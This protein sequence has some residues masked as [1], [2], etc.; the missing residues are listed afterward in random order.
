VLPSTDVVLQFDTCLE[1]I[2]KKATSALD[3]ITKESYD[4]SQYPLLNTLSQHLTHGRP[5]HWPEVNTT[6][7]TAHMTSTWSLPQVKDTTGQSRSS[8]SLCTDQK[9][10]DSST[11]K[12]SPHQKLKSSW[13]NF[14]SKLTETLGR[15]TSGTRVHPAEHTKSETVFR[16]TT[17]VNITPQY[18]S[19]SWDPVRQRF[20]ATHHTVEDAWGTDASCTG[21]SSRISSVSRES[22]T[23]SVTQPTTTS[24]SMSIKTSLQSLT[25]NDVLSW[26]SQIK[27]L[28]AIPLIRALWSSTSL[29]QAAHY[30]FRLLELWNC[31]WNFGLE[32]LKHVATLIADALRRFFRVCSDF[33][34]FVVEQFTDGKTPAFVKTTDERTMRYSDL[35]AQDRDDEMHFQ[36]I[37]DMFK[38]ISSGELD[39]NE[40]ATAVLAMAAPVVMLMTG[41]KITSGESVAKTIVNL[42]NLCR[43][44]KGIGDSFDGL[45]GLVRST[46][47]S[48]LGLEDRSPRGQ[49]VKKLEALRVRLENKRTRL[50]NDPTIVAS[51]TEFI[52]DLN[53]DLVEVNQMH[54]TIAQSTEN[55]A[56][57]HQMLMI[58]KTLYTELNAKYD[59]IMRTIVGKQVPVVIYLY[60]ESGCGKSEMIKAIVKELSAYHG[61]TLLTYTRAKND[62]YWSKYAGQKIVVYDD[63]NSTVECVDHAEMNEIYSG[64]SYLLP[65]AAVE[66]K[67]TRF[68]S[69]YVLIASNHS[70]VA[71]SKVLTNPR[72]LDRR[73]D[74][75]VRV[76]DPVPIRGNQNSH[77]RDHYQPDFSHVELMRMAHFP[78]GEQLP[79]IE[80]VS[81]LQIVNE[82]FTLHQERTAAYDQEVT[83][84][85]A[86]LVQRPPLPQPVPRAPP[87]P[88]QLGQPV[89][90]NPA[91]RGMQNHRGGNR[92]RG[93]N[94]GQRDPMMFVPHWQ[95]DQ[96]PPQGGRFQMDE[97]VWMRDDD[98]HAQGAQTTGTT[99]PVY[100]LFGPPGCGK[101]EVL[102]GMAGRAECY[103]EFCDS[104]ERFSFVLDLVWR[105]YNGELKK[106]L[107]LA[108]NES[109]FR[110][111]TKEWKTEDHDRFFRRLT[112]FYYSFTRVGG[113]LSR[114]AKPSD[115]DNAEWTPQ[116]RTDAYMKYVKVY[117][118][119]GLASRV[120]TSCVTVLQQLQ[121]VKPVVHV[122]ED[123]Q[124]FTMHD[125]VGKADH[126]Y[127]M[128]A[129]TTDK[130]PHSVL[131]L[132]GIVHTSVGELDV[133]KVVMTHMLQW[134]LAYSNHFFD[135]WAS[136]FAGFGCIR[137]PYTGP[138]ME[139]QFEDGISY[140]CWSENGVLL[141]DQIR[142]RTPMPEDL[143]CVAESHSFKLMEYT[144][145]LP[146]LDVVGFLIKIAVGVGL[147]FFVDHKKVE[148]FDAE[149]WG[150]E[151]DERTLQAYG[152]VEEE[153]RA[154]LAAFQQ[155]RSRASRENTRKVGSDPSGSGVFRWRGSEDIVNE[156]VK[157]RTL[158][159]YSE[160][161]R[162]VVPDQLNVEGRTSADQSEQGLIRKLTKPKIVIFEDKPG[163]VVEQ[164][165]AEASVD[166]GARTV[167]VT[168]VRN[169]VQLLDADQK[170]LC[171]GVGLKDR[172][173]MSVLHIKPFVSFVKKADVVYQVEK[174]VAEMENRDVW[175]FTLEKTAPMFPDITQHLMKKQST[176]ASF[177]GS[178][179]FFVQK[180]STEIMCRV[181]SL[182]EIT[183]KTVDGHKVHGL[184]Y[185]GHSDGFSI[186]PIETKNGDC[187]SPVILV[188]SAYPQKFI[189]FHC[190]ASSNIGMCT[191]VYQEDVPMF[192]QATK[193]DI[194]VLRHQN[195]ELYDEPLE[196][197]GR[198]IVIAGRTAD[199]FQQG[200]PPKTHWWPSPFRGLDIGVHF[201][202]AV[203]S[204]KDPR[205][206]LPYA[207]IV[208]GI[209][210]YDIAPRQI[211]EKLLQRA[212]LDISGHI[213]DVFHQHNVQLKILTK[214]E[215]INRTTQYPA[216]NPIYR[217]TS[218]GFPWTSKGV[219]KKDVLFQFDGDIF[220]IAKTPLG[221]ELRHACDQ[222]V[223]TAR[224]GERSAVVFSAANKDEPL[225]PSKIVDTNTR[226][227][228]SSP[229][230]YTI[231]H[232]QYCHAFSAV[233]TGLH[234]FL[235]IKI[236]IDPTGNDWELLHAWHAR[237]GER[238]FAADF[239]A[240]DARLHRQVLL[241]CAD[242]MNNVYRDCDPHFEEVDNTIR[243]SLYKC[244]DGAFVLY[245][246]LILQVPGGQMT[247]QPQTALDNS[248]A[249]WIYTYMAWLMI[250]GERSTF[251]DFL[252]SV[253]CSFYGDDNMMTVDF[254]VSERFHFESYIAQCAKLGL[255]V[256]PAD[257][258]GV[259]KR[260]QPLVDLTFLKRSFYKE[261]GVRFYRGSL[262]INSLQRMLDFT[263]GRPHL[264]Y[265][266]PEAVSWD[267]A[268]ITDVVNNI[269][270]EAFLHGRERFSQIR[271]HIFAKARQWGIRFDKP[272]H[273][274]GDV[275]VI[276]YC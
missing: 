55:L 110:R 73:R 21:R 116:Q 123:G 229:I 239:K 57:L 155:K 100:V 125:Q 138:S 255:D 77:P 91:P 114:T 92:G 211:D 68:R 231:V 64:S 189:G 214:T 53:L 171:F 199:G 157:R 196:I 118:Q 40:I 112:T 42:G 163:V 248:L 31:Y 221:E 49:L 66:E 178:F 246:G 260:L 228:L 183:I 267:G 273:T 266:D 159:T 136:A 241:A 192:G 137:P 276:L 84:R 191:Y 17:H 265:D 242:I 272:I 38:D 54:V 18:R 270:R 24:P 154:A 218:A 252:K 259:V 36:G 3:V 261:P 35:L 33:A 187:G 151:E 158:G 141:M 213:S 16:S 74:F 176:K 119:V 46:V 193:S 185:I 197:P 13:Q 121:D 217:Q 7:D 190:A 174:T 268:L 104:E 146:W 39:N 27:P 156:A 5:M 225:K 72:I 29:A 168:V 152:E 269:L 86:A 257:K 238:G 139:I 134:K 81:F 60:G 188:N 122:V 237:I 71:R 22:V 4:S 43:G 6:L 215:A 169:Q 37:G 93:Q 256:T 232:R 65:M 26:L 150:D 170:F 243:T 162:F 47:G 96:R 247:G 28:N 62:A 180:V 51:E 153:E 108:A 133:L 120:Q 52:K 70:F 103:D 69:T 129:K 219:H 25:I 99:A 50:E 148:K 264:Y 207:P 94:M 200:C 167:M 245:R 143:P 126:V 111:R 175:F 8:T 79:Q 227:I 132:A 9:E 130:V 194:V 222:L 208:N 63:F 59:A 97:D 249:N 244:M 226:S 271:Q 254:V 95:R 76:T 212:V 166:P 34:A 235:P 275:Y 105:T 80:P 147:T 106:P 179:G 115:W 186:S 56:G 98:F 164:F 145:D 117:R 10:S 82:A 61:E 44:L 220:H 12:I 23:P 41:A 144:K 128:K 1:D 107:V 48:F 131:D 101:T 127:W 45:S 67:G 182:E 224:R 20:Y 32:F 234:P 102:K 198:H 223:S 204:E 78:Q 160:G 142:A 75:V 89:F 209:L 2:M 11:R 195:V 253:A 161:S 149:G 83:Q 206:S 88:M 173:C 251:S 140:L 113:L 30:A 181:I 262:D 172:L 58:V 263:T 205:N 230:C 90:D 124:P 203:L 233:M 109:M 258:S 135:T 19:K 202:P 177:T 240:W 14:S 184:T 210:K 201:E 236:G 15:T 165:H 274:W 85:F 250:E 216:S 87:A